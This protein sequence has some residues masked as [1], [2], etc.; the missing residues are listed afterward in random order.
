MNETLMDMQLEASNPTLST[1]AIRGEGVTGMHP[2]TMHHAPRYL[3]HDSRGSPI[4]Q[5]DHDRR[6]Q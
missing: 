5:T 6:L 3:N 1:H 2:C 4:P